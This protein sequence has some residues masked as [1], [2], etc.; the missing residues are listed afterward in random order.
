MKK[1]VNASV[2]EH[3]N[4][5][6]DD[7]KND[8]PDLSADKVVADAGFTMERLMQTRDVPPDAAVF[9]EGHWNR[10][11]GMLASVTCR[12]KCDEVELFLNGETL[13]KKKPVDGKVSWETPFAPGELKAIAYV[14][15]R[16]NGFDAIATA[17]SPTKIVL[18]SSADAIPNG[19][20]AVVVAALADRN[21]NVLPNPDWSKFEFGCKEPGRILQLSETFRPNAPR[22]PF[23]VQ[24]IGDSGESV[25]VTAKY[26]GLGTSHIKI[27]RSIQ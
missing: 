2:A 17:L 11:D 6:A 13:G 25:L 7:L 9:I 23:V 8:I 3:M 14:G 19:G 22:L 16:P 18:E 27:A 21:G 10:E 5:Y 15:G 26:P 24:R 4:D 1:S 12:T 20:A